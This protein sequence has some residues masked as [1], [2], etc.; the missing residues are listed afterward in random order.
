MVSLT[1]RE[2]AA[3][4]VSPS[5]ISTR[6]WARQASPRATQAPAASTSAPR[7]GLAA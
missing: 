7:A 1:E 5:P 3:M 6:Q 4:V 2:H